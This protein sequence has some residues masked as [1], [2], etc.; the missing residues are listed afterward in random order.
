MLA[1]ED[2]LLVSSLVLQEQA[3][4]RRMKVHGTPQR[5][6]YSRYLRKIVAAGNKISLFSQENET[7]PNRLR[8]MK[9]ALQLIDPSRPTSAQ[10]Q[11]AAEDL[12]VFGESGE[13]IRCLLN[14]TPG[15]GERHYDMILIGLDTDAADTH[16][17]SGKV[18]CISSK[19]IPGPNASDKVKTIARYPGKPVYSICAY[20][21]SSLITAA[22]TE[23]ILQSLDVGLRKWSTLNRFTLPS[24]AISLSTQ[25]SLIFAGTTLHS[26]ITLKEQNNT[27][28]FHSSDLR[29]RN[30]TNVLTSAGSCTLITAASYTGTSLLGFSEQLMHNKSDLLF[31][32][33]IPLTI[34]RIRQSHQT[35]NQDSRRY[36]HGTT[37]D[38]TIYRFMT[39]Q[40]REWQ[41]LRFLESLSPLKPNNSET[42]SDSGMSLDDDW[43][44]VSPNSAT[45]SQGAPHFDPAQMHI[46]GDVLASMIQ[47]GPYS[48]RSLLSSEIKIEDD[49]RQNTRYSELKRLATPVIGQM[50]DVIGCTTRWLRKL[51]RMPQ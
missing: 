14:W 34:E 20:G 19:H 23:L 3:V 2:E 48:L 10:E 8:T 49:S 21:P 33:T 22:G 17:R 32:A 12:V 25:G 36:F 37:L 11:I 26:L 46:H 47:S 39:L 41:L 40:I 15:D 42:S 28:S 31:E 1:A 43:E 44:A 4:P 16:K 38:G 7:V 27:F 13:Y 45:S 50:E 18:V 51:L 29:A 6:A 5:L 30:A 35:S 9:P 24:S